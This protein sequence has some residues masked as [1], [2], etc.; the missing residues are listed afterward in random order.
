MVQI[1]RIKAEEVNWMKSTQHRHLQAQNF[2][3]R[4]LFLCEV[5]WN[6]QDSTVCYFRY[7]LPYPSP[8]T[9]KYELNW[10][11]QS[12]SPSPYK[13]LRAKAKAIASKQSK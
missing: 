1:M 9:P 10:K 13:S 6:H 4:F 3:L 11:V 8:L 7:R 2:L 12:S 5:N